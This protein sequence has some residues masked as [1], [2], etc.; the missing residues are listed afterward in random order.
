MGITVAVDLTGIQV[1]RRI[2]IIG[3]VDI[4]QEQVGETVEFVVG[5]EG[6]RVDTQRLGQVVG[7]GEDVL[8]EVV[9]LGGTLVTDADGT[10]GNLAPR[11]SRWS[12]TRT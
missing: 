5:T 6:N 8:I 2:E 12:R 7:Q 1:F 10:V 9:G 4:L 3:T 11:G